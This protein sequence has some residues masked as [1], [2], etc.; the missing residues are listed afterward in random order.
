MTAVTHTEQILFNN[1]N[2]YRDVEGT[3]FIQ[4]HGN[5]LAIFDQRKASGVPGNSAK[6]N[7]PKKI[8]EMLTGEGWKPGDPVVFYGCNTGKEGDV[9]IA[10]R[11]AE[12]YGG[13]ISAPDS[14]V[15]SDGPPIRDHH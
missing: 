1:A 15:C 10:Y 9:S 12:T 6:L 4:S 3:F 14:F 13:Q 8:A 2:Q 7:T 11:I 5:D